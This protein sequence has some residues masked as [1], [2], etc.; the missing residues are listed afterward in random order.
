MRMY[1]VDALTSEENCSGHRRVCLGD[2]FPEASS[3]RKLLEENGL[4]KII[5]AVRNEKGYDLRCF[6][7][8]GEEN[9]SGEDILAGGCAISSETGNP[10]DPLLF[11]TRTGFYSLRQE[12]GLYK[13][14]MNAEKPEVYTPGRLPGSGQ[15][16]NKNVLEIALSRCV[17]LRMDSEEAVRDFD[18]E[19]YWSEVPEGL[20]LIVT[21]QCPGKD[22]DLAYRFFVRTPVLEC[23]LIEMFYGA[24]V[25]FW[26]EKLPKALMKARRLAGDCGTILCGAENGSVFISLSPQ[27][28]P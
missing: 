25:S 21:A 17:I 11:F 3:V 23:S 4:R 13:L 12:D 27:R 8:E 7:P 15:M 18:P 5:F 16:N 9:L 28:S 19:G 20:G 26:D 1:V 6:T 24:L 22:Y 14:K 10:P 2:G